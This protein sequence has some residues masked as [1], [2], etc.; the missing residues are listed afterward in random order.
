VSPGQIFFK[1]FFVCGRLNIVSQ[2][3]SKNIV[4][5]RQKRVEQCFLDQTTNK[6][7]RVEKFPLQKLS[8]FFCVSIMGKY[9]FSYCF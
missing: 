5:C 8:K 1:I 3:N 6:R 2:A 9:M 7:C 4:Y